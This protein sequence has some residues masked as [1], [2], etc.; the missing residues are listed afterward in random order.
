MNEEL[1]KN[2]KLNQCY[3]KYTGFL[4]SLAENKD[5][6][7]GG[8]AR[9]NEREILARFRESARTGSPIEVLKYVQRYF[10]DLPDDLSQFEQTKIEDIYLM[11]AGLFGLYSPRNRQATDKYSNL[12]T[13]L[14][15]Y[16]R[17][18]NKNK[19][20]SKDDNSTTSTEKRFMVLLRAT[21]EELPQYLKQTIQLLKSQEIPI[22]WLQ[23]LKD[24][25]DWSDD[26]KFVQR[27]WAKGFWGNKNTENEEKGE[28]KQ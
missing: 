26:R 18:T 6:P 21:E 1:T 11:L 3:F 24:I 7:R 14:S 22:N 5:K 13:S 28:E 10:D 17:K 4:Y 16:E 19:T 15:E 9:G 8:T 12:G 20:K 25:K 2:Q 23:L 27:N